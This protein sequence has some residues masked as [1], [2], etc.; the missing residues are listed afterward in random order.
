MQ[1]YACLAASGRGS[2]C[3]ALCCQLSGTVR[4]YDVEL[5]VLARAVASGVG[6]ILTLLGT[7]DVVDP[8]LAQKFNQFSADQ[9]LHQPTPFAVE[10][11]VR[12]FQLLAVFFC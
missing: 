6:D 8:A 1:F 7:S 9:R 4:H 11:S 10:L 2:N 5:F 3:P 12:L